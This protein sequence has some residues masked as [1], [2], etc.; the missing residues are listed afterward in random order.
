M[1]K[2]VPMWLPY[3][4]SVVDHK[5]GLWQFKYNGGEEVTTL[6]NIASIM[7]Y[8]D[9]D[10]KLEIKQMEKIARR[11][12][13][14][15]IYRRNM[16][17]PIYIYGG[18][19]PDVDDTLTYQLIKREQSR[20]STHIA[21]QLLI[22]KMKGMSYLIEPIELPR[23]ATIEELRNIEAMHAKRYWKQFFTQL[24]H[25]EWSRRKSNPAST[26]LN[27]VSHFLAGLI[28]RWITYH[29]LSPYHGFLHVTTEY[30]SLVYDIMEPYRGLIDVQLLKTFQSTATEKWIGVTINDIKALLD[31]KTYVPLTRQIVTKHELFHGCVLS[32]KYY[33]LGRQPRFLIPLPGKPNGGRPPKVNFILYGRQAGK[34]DFWQEA[35]MI[36]N[37]QK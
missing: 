20:Y 34:T 9:S 5:D 37:T 3:L 35:R 22:A 30:P 13:P 8:G 21:R 10:I 7:I 15:I 11:G 29:H 4:N 6:D 32:L 31:E 33:L 24:N 18:V 25:P 36:S 19:R 27:A 2:K 14:I 26:A 1:S 16:A 28:L 17:Q 23:L 12:I